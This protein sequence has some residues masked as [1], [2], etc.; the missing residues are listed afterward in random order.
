MMKKVELID[1]IRLDLEKEEEAIRLYEEQVSKTSNS[2]A[3]KILTS[4][5]NEER[6][7]VGE[8]TKLLEI[9]DGECEYMKEGMN[10]VEGKLKM[11]ISFHNEPPKQRVRRRRKGLGLFYLGGMRR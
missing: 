7:H 4:I 5:A 3:K 2:E 6:V 11:P 8:L 1:G 9:L 10:E